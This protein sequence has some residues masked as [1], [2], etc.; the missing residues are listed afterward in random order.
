MS[1]IDHRFEDV[2][3]DG[4]PVSVRECKALEL[5]RGVRKIAPYEPPKHIDVDSAAKAEASIIFE[6][7]A[8]EGLERFGVLKGRWKGSELR[9]TGVQ[10]MSEHAAERT[11]VSNT[12][13]DQFRRELIMNSREARYGGGNVV[14]H[15]HVHFGDDQMSFN[16]QEFFERSPASVFAII[17]G[18]KFEFQ[19][20][21][22]VYFNIRFYHCDPTI[23]KQTD[24]TSVKYQKKIGDAGSERLAY[25]QDFTEACNHTYD[26]E[27]KNGAET[28]RKLVLSK[29]PKDRKRADVLRE[30]YSNMVDYFD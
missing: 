7:A 13:H 8:E 15:I 26:T 25:W 19:K 9:V 14:G 1:K 17:R 22:N 2:G 28:Y 10:D 24:V 3:L 23:G 27:L 30:K 16:D 5:R 18:T 29:E 21:N 11:L 20:D 4:W 12:Y 6:K